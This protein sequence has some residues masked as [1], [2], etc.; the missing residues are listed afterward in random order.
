MKKLIKPLVLAICISVIA[1][2]ISDKFIGA[3]YSY[4]SKR[5]TGERRND[6]IYRTTHWDII[7]QDAYYDIKDRNEK[8]DSRRISKNA[9]ID[10][11][12]YRLAEIK[13]VKLFNSNALLISIAVAIVS[14]T[15][16]YK[17]KKDE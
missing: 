10:N 2:I 17:H 8:I 6:S 14:F 3:S 1:F 5:V 12:E 4:H 13:R 15:L 9:S 11:Y 7:T 16:M